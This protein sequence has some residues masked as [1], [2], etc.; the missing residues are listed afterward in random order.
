MVVRIVSLWVVALSVCACSE[1]ASR[2]GAGTNATHAAW[3]ITDDEIGTLRLGEPFS[4]PQNGFEASYRTSFYGDRQPL[5]GFEFSDPP[6]F[7][8][9]KGGPFSVWGATHVGREAP[10][11]IRTRAIALAGAKRFKVEMLITTDARAK[12]AAGISVGD[13]YAAFARAYPTAP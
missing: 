11:P 2:E 7:A 8:V 13:D 5:E 10:E 1:A 6:V 9:F 4:E 12:T 3:M